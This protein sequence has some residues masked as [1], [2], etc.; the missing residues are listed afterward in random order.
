ML[1]EPEIQ[2]FLA[3]NQNTA[4][5]VRRAAT[6]LEG[7][8]DHSSALKKLLPA[9]ASQ[10]INVFFSYKKKDERA[11]RT[12]V[13]VLRESAAGKLRITYRAE[14][15]QAI[16]GKPWRNKISKDVR[17]ANWFI[18]LLPDPSE[19]LDWCLFETGLFEAQLTAAD[20]LICL[21]HP[22]TTVPSPIEGYHSIAATLPE[23]E[24]FLRMVFVED[25]PI[26][27]M[28]AI[29]PAVEGRI[30]ELSQRVVDAIRIPKSRMNRVVFEP[31]IE[32]RL[33]D[34]AGLQSADGLDSATVVSANKEALDLFGLLECRATFGELRE[35]IEERKGDGRWRSELFHVVRKVSKGKRFFP[36]QAVFQSHTG[37]MYRPVA[38]AI[39]RAGP[40]GPIQ[41]Y[42]ITFAED[43]STADTAAMPSK[44]AMLATLLRFAFRFRW[45]VL[46]PFSRGPLTEWD[47]TRLDISLRRI[48]ADWQSRGSISQEGITNLFT[49]EQAK[50][51]DEMFKIWS[52]LRNS[53]G[54]GE[55]DV[56]LAAKDGVRVP[57]ILASFL[58]A[59]QDFLETAADR[60]SEMVAETHET[61]PTKPALTV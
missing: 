4:E 32:I 48:R 3:A 17:G 51:V 40:T 45:E 2:R 23:V 56:A 39:D 15:T 27:G 22:D 24:K 37:R 14:F 59:N 11:A 34:A 19:E 9:L 18:L 60:F 61:A 29:N 49:S 58:P 38:L 41:T 10:E 54:T 21:H 31:W 52:R 47:V 35:G 36:I 5:R 25:N 50:R 33:D 7:Q 13:A 44:L 6:L 28:P 30:P 57:T 53:E 43:V 42:H 55:L 46:E 20:R 16:A 8:A 12:I 1:N 26:F